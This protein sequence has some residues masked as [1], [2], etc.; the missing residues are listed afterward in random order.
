MK[1][2]EI[3][4]NKKLNLKIYGY[5]LP[6][7]STHEGC[8]KV[9]ETTQDDVQARIIQQVGTV[10]IKHELLFQ[11]SAFRVDGQLFHDKDLHNY[12]RLRGIERAILNGQASEWFRFGDTSLAEKMTDDYIYRDYDEVQISNDK[13]DYILRAEQQEA[14]I[15]TL[16]Y[17]NNPI[18]GPEF[19]WNAKPRF[20]KTLTTY[21]FVRKIKAQN[22]LIVTNRPAIANS[23]FDDFMKF[24]AWQEPGMKFISETDALSD[25][26]TMSRQQYLDFILSAES[27][28]VT[29]R[30]VAFISLQDLKGAKF[31]GGLYDKLKWV[32]GMDWDVLIID[33]AHEGIDTQK[34]DRAFDKIKRNFTLH[35]SGT[36]FK[37]IANQKFHDDQIYNWSYLDEQKAKTEWDE[38][39]NGTNPYAA[40]PT[41]NLFTYQMSK[42]IEQEVS[43]GISLEDGTNLDYTFSLFEFFS[44]KED[45]SFVYESDV[46]TFLDNLSEGKFPFADKSHRH[47]LNHTFWL[48]PRVAAA[49]AME[50]LLKKHPFFKDY[51]VVLAAGDGIS[52]QDDENIEALE[53]IATDEK[54]NKQSY[55]KVK[56]AIAENEKTI[57]LS[58]TQLTTGVT[59]REWTAVM[60]LSDIRSPA[61]YFQAAFRAQNPHE[62]QDE[63]TKEWYRK[64]NAYVFD[65]AP[66][67]T[68]ILFDEFANNLTGEG[69][70]GST[71]ERQDNIRELINFFPVIA[72]DD[73]G[74]MH[75]ISAEEILTIPS[76]IK[77]KEV[78]RRGFMSNL[79]FANISAIFSTP[80]YKN[81][82]DKIPPEK[83]ARLGER[84]KIVVTNPMLDEEGEVKV[85]STIT[86]NT[87]NGLFGQ[88]IYRTNIEETL[89]KYADITDRLQAAE[90]VAKDVV[91]QLREGFLSTGKKFD[92]PKKLVAKDEKDAEKALI[93]KIEENIYQR[94]EKERIAREEYEQSLVILESQQEKDERIFQFKSELEAIEVSFVSDVEA[95]IH[96]VAQSVVETHL[97]RQ[98]QAKKK[99]TEDD[100]RDHL[101]GF[102]RTIP[103]F[104]M[105]YGNE[106]TTLAN[107]DAHIS[108][109][110]FEELTSIT[111]DEF[112]MLR[113]GL[114][115]E[116]EHGETKTIKGLFNEVVFNAAVTEFFKQKAR[117]ADYLNAENDE[118]IFDYIPPQKTNQIFTPRRIVE[119][120]VDILEERNPD[121]F[122]RT[123]VTFVDFYAKSGLYLTEVAKRLFMGLESKI[124]DKDRRIAWILENQIYACA[125]SNIIYNI[126]KNY[127]YAGFPHVS[128]KNLIELDM[129]EAALQN[130]MKSVLLERIGVNMKFDIAIGNPPYQEE[131]LGTSDNP[132][133]HLFMSQAYQLSE[134]ACFITPARFLFNAGKTPKAWNREMLN[135][136]HLEVAFY[137][138]DSSKVFP[139][140]VEIKGGIA[141]T[142]RD[143]SQKR[144]PILT[145]TPHL[146][147]SRI[148]SKVKKHTDFR[149]LSN[150]V[151]LQNKFL[152]DALYA[153]K[154]EYVN[155]IGSGGRERRLTTSIFSQLDVFTS[156]MVHDDDLKVLGLINNTRVYRFIPSKYVE[157]T[158]NTHKFKVVLPKTNSSGGLGEEL[159]SPV[160]GEPGLGYTQ[161]FI[162]IGNFDT[163]FEAES[164]LNYIK[165]KFARAMLG[166]LK[167][168]QDNNRDTWKNVPMQD[169]S[170]HSDIDWRRSINEIDQQLYKKYGLSSE[171]I[172]FIEAQ[173]RPME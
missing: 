57:T 133:Y 97:E 127:V 91:S 60:M 9:G 110:T 72:E 74:I 161:S 77:A 164:A 99:T 151:Y 116:D 56:K 102:T 162:G 31:A 101:R 111:L 43:A 35:L 46:I 149:P 20:G 89:E 159:S 92:L 23:W 160:I 65:F 25:K 11:R 36:P 105:A 84:R 73:N 18:H 137:E 173:I 78:V 155:I 129:A 59:I 87:T 61:L 157:T 42:I 148:L 163:L 117:L 172:A 28:D 70:R 165:T 98:E 145:F 27:E 62:F 13:V 135:D 136:P 69:S 19:L 122:T 90:K 26:A 32:G 147:L 34:T 58:V 2:T 38:A 49:K 50:R 88:P 128:S 142:L 104:L 1:K 124:P 67:R 82:L 168:T 170:K 64:E 39:T 139:N 118:D 75:E 41:L 55:D 52:L 109:D 33:E 48:L 79:L 166:T 71:G 83:N 123:D 114:E 45:G 132:I 29:P 169:F 134:K 37:A 86:I 167:V 44:T 108:P 8:V 156:N 40:L 80:Q 171:E 47:H 112:R 100:V 54:R 150:I 113:D 10:G 30:C 96:E 106:Q 103:A 138:E 81:I 16:A 14:V 153:D 12:Y 51:E 6:H 125:P 3:V 146:E 63:V 68:L 144:G 7:V 143:K 130:S 93:S 24:I 152:L 94:E 131:T 53:T 158:V 154:P 17:W 141:V 95:S 76:H 115:Y 126:V 66:D 21:D 119:M 5:S 22:I 140:S 4:P 120:M 121:I 85:D 107:F 15:T